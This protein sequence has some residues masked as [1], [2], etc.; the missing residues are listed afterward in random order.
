VA[1][2]LEQKQKRMEKNP[3]KL[4]KAKRR[5]KFKFLIILISLAMFVVLAITFKSVGA[6]SAFDSVIS[7]NDPLI[8]TNGTYSMDFTSTYE[9]ALDNSNCDIA[10][11]TA[12]DTAKTETG[13]FA[14]TRSPYNQERYVNIIYNT[15]AT[16]AFSF[17]DYGSFQALSKTSVTQ[18]TATLY[19]TGNGTYGVACTQ[20]T[21]T[22]YLDRSTTGFDIHLV[23][24]VPITYPT[25][26]E[27]LEVPNDEPPAIDWS[28]TIQIASEIFVRYYE[29]DPPKNE[30]EELS[31]TWTGFVNECS[32]DMQDRWATALNSGSWYVTRQDSIYDDVEGS[33]VYVAWSTTPMELNWILG[34][35]AQVPTLIDNDSVRDYI[36]IHYQ[37]LYGEFGLYVGCYPNSGNNIILSNEP[38]EEVG[39]N[40]SL[41]WLSNW[42]MTYPE[43]YTGEEIPLERTPNVY[44]SPRFSY[45]VDGRY[46]TAS[47]KKN[48]FPNVDTPVA[49][50]WVLR[51]ENAGIVDLKTLGDS[52]EYAFEVPALGT[53]ELTLEYWLEDM[54]LWPEWLHVTNTT[55]QFVIDGT[56]YQGDTID[57]DCTDGYCL[58]TE[59]YEDCSIYGI[60][61]VGGRIACEIG[62]FGTWLKVTLYN[63]FVPRN[64]ATTFG[65]LQTTFTEQLGFLT[66]PLTFFYDV[67]S[68]LIAVNTATCSFTTPSLNGFFGNN[69]MTINFC[70]I[71]DN[72]NTMWLAMSVLITAGVSYWMMVRLYHKYMEIVSKGES[73][74]TPI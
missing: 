39:Y 55:K 25:G 7:I 17:V 28:E 40:N 64:L 66:F 20:G 24:N 33:R 23:H 13:W 43:G 46:V 34:G 32:T 56:S 16:T 2:I 73:G 37:E 42:P 51:D 69:G 49:L 9:S 31:A 44:I 27:G 3:L 68:S 15:Y 60:T 74:A 70:V 8:A 1:E 59:V 26:Y 57:D 71:K 36:D 47:Y 62:N 58:M 35:T 12:F 48:I 5:S 10:Y 72:D 50:V 63:L 11:K 67:F 29:V 45:N 61:D 22:Q 53:Y 52:Q 21:N 18:R 54:D 41:I 19:V 6:T 4:D 30:W 14:L 65:N 38:T